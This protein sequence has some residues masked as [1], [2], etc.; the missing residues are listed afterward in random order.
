MFL[1]FADVI[2]SQNIKLLHYLFLILGIILV[3]NILIKV[4]RFREE[5]KYESNKTTIN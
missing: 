4:S 5:K 2:H 3:L 1:H